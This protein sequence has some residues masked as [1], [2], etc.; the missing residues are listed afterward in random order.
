MAN[1]KFDKN[2]YLT[3]G[4]FIC[5][6]AVVKDCFFCY[7]F[8]ILLIVEFGEMVNQ[9]DGSVIDEILNRRTV[10]LIDRNEKTRR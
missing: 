9:R 5:E 3:V 6:K 2:S 4:A 10:P 8:V 1:C 7:T